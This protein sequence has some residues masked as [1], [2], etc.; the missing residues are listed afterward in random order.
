MPL[1]PRPAGFALL[2]LSLLPLQEMVIQADFTTSRK[3]QKKIAQKA[4][5]LAENCLR[6]NPND[7]ACLYYR[8]QAIGLSNRSFFGYTKRVRQMIQDWEKVK[9]IDPTFDHGGPYRMI[10]EVYME[11]PKSFGPKDLRQ[12]LNRSIEYLEKATQIS[13]YPTNYLDLADAYLQFKKTQ[14][15]QKAFEKA[16]QSLPKWSQDP[17]YR[18]WQQRLKKLEVAISSAL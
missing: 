18:D 12:D 17:Y 11:L 9:Q 4:L 6:I 5:N 8:A 2:L 14:A 16:K 13:D 15:A 1:F 7:V 10:A 3:E